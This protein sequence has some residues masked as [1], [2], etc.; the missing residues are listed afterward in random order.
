QT[1]TQKCTVQGLDLLCPF[2]QRLP[3]DLYDWLVLD[4]TSYETRVDALLDSIF[5][6]TH[7]PSCP[8]PAGTLSRAGIDCGRTL[9]GQ[10][11][12]A[13]SQV[14]QCIAKCEIAV[15]KSGGEACV[16]FATGEVVD[17]KTIDCIGRVRER[18][19]SVLASRCTDATVVELGCPLAATTESAMLSALDGEFSAFTTELS[20]DLF[21][22]SCRTY[23]PVG[24][25][26][27]TA[28]ATLLPS[29]NPV[30]VHCG[31]TL[32]AA[33]FGTD[34]QLLLAHDL[35]CADAG[36]TDGLVIA[37]SGVQLNLGDSFRISGPRR[38]SERTGVGVRIAA[39]A[40]GVLVNRGLVQKFGIGIAD[41]DSTCADSTIREIQVRDN[42]AQGIVMKGLRTR[43]DTL[44]V[45]N[46]GGDG[47]VLDASNGTLTASTCEDNGGAGAVVNGFDNEVESNSFGNLRDRGN[48]GHGLVVNASGNRVY[49]NS[50]AVNGGDGLRIL[51]AT[52]P[53][54]DS[55]TA[56]GN[57]GVGIRIASAGS[58]VE[59]NRSEKNGDFE[60]VIAAGNTDLGN[61]RANGSVFA[62]PPA[63][64]SYE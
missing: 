27:T 21:H 30:E 11:P 7:A 4:P 14:Q 56:V 38:A 61:N 23:I 10:L 12:K 63:G 33:F 64:G 39:G 20:R 9:S 35:D 57:G 58:Q 48:V 31:Q 1:S 60:Y 42:A 55:N 34:T 45:K 47:V 25:V 41:T 44:S 2:E 40:T 19:F 15:T 53:I 51:A 16:D 37:S 18:L 29:G 46:N 3:S 54:F 26:P 6:T 17:A 52:A 22:S 13:L 36:A 50:A 49:S 5:R 43:L 32:D 28:A 62:F 59:S 8:R 24:L